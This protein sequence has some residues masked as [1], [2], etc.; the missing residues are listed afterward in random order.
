MWRSFRTAGRRP[1][2]DTVEG[3]GVERRRFGYRRIHVVLR[4]EGWMVNIERTRRLYI[5]LGLQ[6]RA[7]TPKRRVR[8]KL[9]KIAARL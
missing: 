5:G 7:K 9:R 6:L 4:R 3:A 8:A 1:P 2:A